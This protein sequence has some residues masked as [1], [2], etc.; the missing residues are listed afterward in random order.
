MSPVMDMDESWTY[1]LEELIFSFQFNINTCCYIKYIFRNTAKLKM[2]NLRTDALFKNIH[3]KYFL[4]ALFRFD[5]MTH[6]PFTLLFKNQ[7]E[8]FANTWEGDKNSRAYITGKLS[9]LK[10]FPKFTFKTFSKIF[11]DS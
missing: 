9:L 8:V 5:R 7:N 11:L 2:T 6:C 4:A 1:P 10:L 3:F